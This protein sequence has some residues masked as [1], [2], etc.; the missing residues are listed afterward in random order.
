MYQTDLSVNV[1]GLRMKN[2]VM[3]ASG[4]YDYFENNANVFAMEELGAIVLK[5]VHRHPRPGNK[6]PRMAEVE[7]G[8]INAVGIPS[9]GIEEYIH[10]KAERARYAALNVP[11][12]LSLSGSRAEDYAQS[13]KLLCGHDAH[14]AAL[15]LNLSCPNVGTG[16]AFASDPMV[17]KGVVS[18]ARAHTALP[19]FVKLSPN[20][21]DIVPMVR[22]AE[23]SGADAVIISNT[24]MGM[25]IDIEKQ[26]PYL[27][28]IMGG[29]SGPCI[30]PVVM[31]MVYQAYKVAKIPIIGCGG[32]TCWQDA[33][34]YILAGATAL[35]VG[36]G[37]F[38]NPMLMV[39]AIKGID[40]YLRQ[41]GCRSLCE[42][43]GKAHRT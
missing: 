36:C 21:A 41:K 24:V 30:K 10:N 40:G 11:V 33:V 17:L 31:R 23:Q 9:E 16:L 12:V 8:M 1:G 15:E 37:N 6:V 34:E 27:G 14:I 38:A 43:R 20:V 7:G 22:A 13:V 2:P 39:E 29:L 19:L 35:Q 3:P 5:S 4:T 26:R 32:I 28:N 25:V 18:G 42:I